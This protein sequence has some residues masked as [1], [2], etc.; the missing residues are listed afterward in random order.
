MKENEIKIRNYTDNCFE[1]L[2]ELAFGFAVKYL[3][4]YRSREDIKCC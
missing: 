3:Q 2:Y 4:L 1:A